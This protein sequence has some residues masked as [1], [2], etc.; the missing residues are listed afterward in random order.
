MSAASAPMPALGRADTQAIMRQIA[1]AAPRSGDGGFELRLSPEELGSVRLRMVP[2]EAGI[3][4][5][6]QAD[7]PETL[8]L[9]RRN[10]DQLAQDLARSG[11]EAAGFSFGGD[12]AAGNGSE[13]RDDNTAAGAAGGMQATADPEATI[14]MAQSA[15]QATR[16]IDIRL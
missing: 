7:R 10:I 1:D 8:D 15:P 5:Y 3:M 14:P 6:V 2:G 4:V 16:G 9:L 11:T 12:S 13:A